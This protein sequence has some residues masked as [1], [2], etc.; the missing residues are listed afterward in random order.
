[1]N[2][3]VQVLPNS[4]AD[5]IDQAAKATAEAI[6]RGNMRCQVRLPPGATPAAAV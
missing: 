1:M 6:Q 5:S 4:L 3:T 2:L